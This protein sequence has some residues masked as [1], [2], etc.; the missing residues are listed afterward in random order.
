MSP[1]FPSKNKLT[2][3]VASAVLALAALSAQ[4]G[5]TAAAKGQAF[6]PPASNEVVVSDRDW[7]HFLFPEKVVRGPYFPD[8]APIPPGS[9]PV[10]LAGNTQFLL[11]IQRGA[12]D[13]FQM[14]VETESGAVHKL[15]LKPSPVAGTTFRVKGGGSFAATTVR[16]TAAQPSAPAGR[17]E[18]VDL[19]KRLVVGDI[20]ADMET[21]KLPVPVR[22]TSFTAVPMAM[23][24]GGGRRVAVF[25]LVATGGKTSAVAP[26]QFYRPGVTAVLLDGDQVA[27]GV[28]PTLFVLENMTDE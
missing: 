23:W 19:L 27:P 15:Y 10:W 22:F 3:F 11:Q 21:V 9:K 6:E 25:N 28:A 20:P 24:E 17:A 5:D 14:V 1:R 12:G 7:N 18:D 26:P 4:A 2:G 8:S 16:P 13:R